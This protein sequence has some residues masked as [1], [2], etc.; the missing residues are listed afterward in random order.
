MKYFAY[1]ELSRVATGS[2]ASAQA[3]RQALFG[4][5]VV[6]GG[7]AALWSAFVREALLVLGR[8]YQVLVRRGA[9]AP[10][11]AASSGAG[12][13]TPSGFA[14]FAS[15]FG[16]NPNPNNGLPSTPAKPKSPEQFRIFFVFHI[17]SM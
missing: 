10:P 8:D 6:K 17:P 15:T 2:T 5:D 9:P 14:P 11:P 3:H 1:A 12:S 13:G 4:N 16:V 7:S